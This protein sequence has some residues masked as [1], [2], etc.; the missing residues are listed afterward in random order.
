MTLSQTESSRILENPH[1]KI[2]RSVIKIAAWTLGIIIF[3]IGAGV[4]GHRSFRKWQE[5]R[6]V[7]QAN[8]LVNEGELKAASLDAR[9]IIQI[10]PESAEGCRIMARITERAESPTAVEWRRRAADLAAGSAADL[11]ALAKTASRFDDVANRDYALSRLPEEAKNSAEYHSVEADIAQARRDAAGMAEHLQEAVRL[12][13]ANKEYASRLAAVQLSAADRQVREQG[14]Q[15]LLQLQ[16]DPASRREATRRLIDDALRRNEFDV[17]VGYGRQLQEMPEREFS[18]QLLLLRALHGAI[19]PGFTAFLQQL[20]AEAAA[21]PDRIAKLISWFNAN[22]MPAAAVTWAAQLSPD[23]MARR[24]VPIA[25]SDSYIAVQ[26]WAQLQR[27]VKDGNWGGFEFL[28]T[29]LAAR[30]LREQGNHMESAAQW[31]E[32]MKKAGDDSKLAVTLAEIVQKWGWRDE[33]IELFWAASKHPAKGDEALQALYRHFASTGASQEL[34]RVLLHRREFRPDDLNV[35]NNIAQLSLLLNL[36]AEQGQR[37]ASDLYEREPANPA[38]AS[39]YAFALY[40]KGDTKKALAVFNSMKPEDLRRPEIAAYYGAVLAAAG[41]QQQAE[42]FL[43]LGE[44][45]QLLPEERTL[46]ER[47]RRT[48]AKR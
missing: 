21:D 32:A 35:Q 14:R 27:L 33:A 24:A 18:D 29:A 31:A 47:A 13:P 38:Y 42:E 11:L 25:L 36:N 48:L 28:R 9:R 8:A 16:N 46:I 40:T 15:T 3:L 19:D 2:E 41:E 20:Q 22:K 6:L 34:Y 7:A 37:F 17:A 30:A 12:D 4:L 26:D 43:A 39:T 5:R 23:V 44:T 45:A 1:N 10:N